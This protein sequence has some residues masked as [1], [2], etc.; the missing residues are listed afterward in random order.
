MKKRTATVSLLL[1]VTLILGG[2]TDQQPKITEATIEND[3]LEHGVWLAWWMSG[4]SG[5]KSISDLT[6]TKSQ[7]GDNGIYY[8]VSM[9]YK[10]ADG[11]GGGENETVKVSYEKFDQG[12]QFV[13]ADFTD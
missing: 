11:S 9:S 2:C 1:L 12:W 5:L 6:I 8:W 13:R 4:P 3:L 7:T 10:W